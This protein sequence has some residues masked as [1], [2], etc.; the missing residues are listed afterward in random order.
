[1]TSSS[2]RKIFSGLDERR[3]AAGLTVGRLCALA[4][5]TERSYRRI[6]A[7][8]RP[9]PATLDKLRAALDG[10]TPRLPLE[11]V[12]GLVRTATA[13]LAA[14]SGAKPELMLAQDFSV[15]R[16]FNR[17]W[18]EAA[19]LRRLAIAILI[20]EL[21]LERG[22]VGR[23]LGMTRQ[24]VHATLN[25]VALQEED[26]DVRALSRRVAKLMRGAA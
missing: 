26:P 4:G 13:L 20:A 10:A 12:P 14:L 1:M 9:S 8:A 6:L 11:L 16:P 23:A 2:E 3:Q 5:V 19:K 18:L 17:D 7:G 22:A 21:G 15:Q 24:A 25:D